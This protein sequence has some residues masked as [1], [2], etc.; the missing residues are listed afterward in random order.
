MIFEIR[1]NQEQKEIVAD[2]SFRLQDLI[3]EVNKWTNYDIDVG[4]SQQTRP[5]QFLPAEMHLREAYNVLA[6]VMGRLTLGDLVRKKGEADS[7]SSDRP[8]I[9]P[10]DEIPA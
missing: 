2:L 7:P 3:E 6:Q 4:V 1:S 9:P 5:S 10:S 8:G